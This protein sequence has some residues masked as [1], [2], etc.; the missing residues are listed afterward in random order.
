MNILQ[1]IIIAVTSGAVVSIFNYLFTK[2]KEKRDI[3]IKSYSSL[4]D[5]A[6]AF[7]D[8]PSLSKEQRREVKKEFLKK[9]YNDII[10]FADKNVQN[11][12]EDFIKTGGVSATNPSEQV[13]KLGK[14]I[15]AIRKDLGHKENV[16]DNFKMYSLDIEEERD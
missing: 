8:D 1:N 6:R 16:S 9:Y 13:I 7:L 14:I 3:K 2:D 12:T 15:N 11:K 10:L 4:L 5:N